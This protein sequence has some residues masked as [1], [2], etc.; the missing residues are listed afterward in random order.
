MSVAW[1]GE[2]VSV[3]EVLL[4]VGGEEEEGG[5]VWKGICFEVVDIFGCENR[6]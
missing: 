1:E 2:G 3:N 5:K 6:M 4:G